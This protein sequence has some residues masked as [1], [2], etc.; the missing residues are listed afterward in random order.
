MYRSSVVVFVLG[1]VV[2]VGLGLL[3]AQPDPAPLEV[4]PRPEA[5]M[6]SARESTRSHAPELRG[7]APVDGPEANPAPSS[8]QELPPELVQLRDHLTPEARRR[9]AD[10][11]GGIR[12]RAQEMIERAESTALE[13]VVRELEE[14]RAAR[15]DLERGGVMKWLRTLKSDFTPPWEALS[16]SETFGKLF[17][18][19]SPGPQL[20]GPNLDWRA[21]AAERRKLR[22]RRLG[23]GKDPASVKSTI[24]PDG[25]SI[26][27]PPGRFD[28]PLG[29]AF[30]EGAFP[31][32]LLIEGAGMNETVLVLSAELTAR[33]AVH[34]LTFRDL[35][36]HCNDDY[37]E[38]LRREPYTLRLD[39]CRIIGF[40]MGAGSSCMF[41]G[42]AGAIYMVGCR[43]EAGY[44]RSPGSGNLFDVRGALVVRLEDCDVVGPFRSVNY[45]W[46]G[47]AHLFEN[48]R[49]TSMTKSCL[50]TL[51]RSQVGVQ[52]VD[53]TFD[54]LTGEQEKELR[55]A[56]RRPLTEINAAWG[57]PSRR[58]R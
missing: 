13:A 31:K 47:A 49:F 3:V 57:A 43:I 44:G 11:A 41:G 58:G 20:D 54:A 9:A 23:E 2:G 18:R 51:R 37:L 46:S 15:E 53:C 34:S 24:I 1:A 38:A 16:S 5:S 42:Y 45:A 21:H 29:R 22:G 14:E 12:R 35:T 8:E 50:A 56:K 30:R 55:R 33:G 26:L 7:T 48:C 19:Q 52:L 28:V 10:L 39:R 17:E 4:P 25:S 6:R 32:D 40:D 27:Y 36:I